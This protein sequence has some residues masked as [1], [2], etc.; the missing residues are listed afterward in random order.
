V[1]IK[2]TGAYLAKHAHQLSRVIGGLLTGD[3]VSAWTD[4]HVRKLQN[5]SSEALAL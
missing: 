3:K 4:E 5:I 2:S 1:K